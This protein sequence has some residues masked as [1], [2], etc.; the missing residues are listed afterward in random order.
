M[1]RVI[2]DLKRDFPKLATFATLSPLPSMAGWIKRNPDVLAGAG[3]DLTL[4]QLQS[5][6]WAQHTKQQRA[7]RDPLQK[8]GARYLVEAKSGKRPYDPVARFHLGNGARIE[9]LNFLGD[10]SAKGFKQ[11]CGLMVN[12]LYDPDQLEDNVEAFAAEGEVAMTAA[13]RRLARHSG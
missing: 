9:R 8:L 12:Y 7:L 2:D 11:S 10:G 13:V 3:I 4:E 6:E 5:G 1:K